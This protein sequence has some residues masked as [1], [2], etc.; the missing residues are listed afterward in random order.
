M[1]AAMSEL[2]LFL[3]DE[4]A[5][6]ALGAGL[7]RVLCAGETVWLHGALGAGKTTLTRGLLRALGVTGAVKSPTYTLVES[8]ALSGALTAVHHFDLYRIADAAELDFLGLD[9]FITAQSLCLIEWAERGAAALPVPTLEIYLSR[10]GEGRL[11][12]LQIGSGPRATEL[13]DFLSKSIHYV[14]T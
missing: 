10:Q 6:L 7:A 12:R 3:A 11:V 9:E 4:P 14:S 8:Y 2:S 1:P 5:T 13:L